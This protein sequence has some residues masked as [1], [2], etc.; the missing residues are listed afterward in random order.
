MLL[1]MPLS[2][3]SPRKKRKDLINRDI[4]VSKQETRVSLLYFNV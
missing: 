2:I 3:T 1:F 4:F